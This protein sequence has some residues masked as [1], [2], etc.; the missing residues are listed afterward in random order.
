MKILVC[1]KQVLD[2]NQNFKI[3]EG[4]K[5]IVR[6]NL[7]L[8]ENDFDRYAV[9]LALQLKEKH[10]GEVVVLTAGPEKAQ[11]A[12]RKGLAMGADSGIHIHHDQLPLAD[13]K[14]IS[15]LIANA[16]KEDGFDLVLTGVQS[17]DMAYGQT[18]PM[19]AHLLGI[20]HV[21]TV[22]E[23][24]IEGEKAMVKRELE[25]GKLEKIGI[26]LPF[27][28][29]IQTGINT[30][31]YPTLMNIMKAKKKPVRKVPPEELGLEGDLLEGRSTEVIEIGFPP[32]KS[33]GVIL[34]GP[35][36]EVVEKLVTILKEEVKVL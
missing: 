33:G 2:R 7:T 20:P 16:V 19:L 9:E 12:M 1:M 25:G 30:P 21:T 27:L 34:E 10:G 3:Q 24:S 23:L 35:A 18:G 28:A 22:V 13:P 11:E 4:G 14:V 17:E 31:R 29:T 8:V 26:N 5:D 6:E 32:K 36:D 15:R